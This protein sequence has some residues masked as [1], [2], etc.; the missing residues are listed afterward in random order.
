MRSIGINSIGEVSGTV[1]PYTQE[2]NT[3]CCWAISSWCVGETLNPLGKTPKQC[4]E[5]MG[6]T[7]GN[8]P[9]SGNTK[10]LDILTDIYSLSSATYYGYTLSASSMKSLINNDYPF[11]MLWFKNKDTSQIGHSVT[12]YKYDDS[13][14]PVKFKVMDS[15]VPSGSSNWRWMTSSSSDYKITSASNTY[16]YTCTISPTTV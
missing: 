2:P 14:S 15:L 5:E 1:K 3:S 7:W 8:G 12:C 6:V 4:S 16:T 13:Y 9:G 10:Q 11:I